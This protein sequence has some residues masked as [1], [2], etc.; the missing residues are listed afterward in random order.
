MFTIYEMGTQKIDGPTVSV[1]HREEK[2][3]GLQTQFSIQCHF[4][5]IRVVSWGEGVNNKLNT[6]FFKLFSRMTGGL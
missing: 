3:V 6:G 5:G 1:A 2:L 4:K